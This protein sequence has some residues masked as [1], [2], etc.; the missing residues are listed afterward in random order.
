[1]SFNQRISQSTPVNLLAGDCFAPRL[2]TALEALLPL[3]VIGEWFHSD[4]TADLSGV[5]TCAAA[6]HKLE[7]LPAVDRLVL[8]S[9]VSDSVLRSAV[10]IQFEDIDP[11]PWPFRGRSLE[12]EVSVLPSRL[13]LEAD[14]VVLASCDG[15]PVWT[16]AIREGR[17]VFRSA[18]PL[19]DIAGQGSFSLVFSDQ[20]FIQNL[21]LLHLLRHIEGAAIDEVPPLRAAFMFDDPNLHWPTYGCI[22]YREVVARARKNNYHVSFAT[23]PLDTWYTHRSTAEIFRRNPDA[24][25]LL[26]HG[27]NHSK[28]ELARQH[29][30]AD[31]MALLS[32]AQERIQRLEQNTGLEVCRVMVPPHG[33][34]SS[35]ML[36]ALAGAGFEGACI[37]A[38]SLMAHNPQAP[39]I[40]TLGFYPAENIQGC[41]V[42]PRAAFTGRARN[43]ALICAYLGRP[44]VLRGHQD[45]L[46]NGIELLDELAEFVNELGAVTWTKLSSLM[47]MSYT[48]RLEGQTCHLTP[49]A[50]RVNFKVPAAAQRLV[51]APPPW[52]QASSFLITFPTGSARVRP[53]ECFSLAG[54]EGQRIQLVLET[55]A[56]PV[57]LPRTPRTP[58]SLILRRLLTEGRDRFLPA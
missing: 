14:E 12:S 45:D 42:L 43:A 52:Q 10:R 20:A 35:D 19:L 17:A 8:P 15:R 27:N 1:M 16:V 31:R 34:C 5:L 9:A 30:A 51:I 28:N 11:V 18:F 21:P 49:L 33:G 32:Q 53:G 26:V 47:R 55:S 13:E 48:Q 57:E 58:A 2:L 22:D 37:S 39:W 6:V 3:K 7:S 23:I 40:S 41:T 29:L 56:R 4:D 25:S 24:I 36:G 46:K 50:P 54:R 38:G 44:I